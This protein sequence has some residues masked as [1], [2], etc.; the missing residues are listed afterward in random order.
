[1]KVVI[2]GGQIHELN[3]LKKSIQK[4]AMI[5]ANSINV[6][7]SA[8]D[9][10]DI[11][12]FIR[13]KKADCYILELDRSKSR[14]ELA[15][16]IRNSD[17]L[18]S[19]IL[20]TDNSEILQ[21]AF[22]YKIAVLDYIVKNEHISNNVINSLKIAYKRYRQIGK[23]PY[24][25]Y[26]QIEVGEYVKNIPFNEI[27][28]FESLPNSHKIILQAENSRFEFY[29]TLKKV[30]FN[31]DSRFY[32]CHKSYIVNMNQIDEIDKSNHKIKMKNGEYCYASYRLLKSLIYNMKLTRL[33]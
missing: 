25:P 21:L 3:Q 2:Y 28:F 4:Y 14:F 8:T 33:V 12:K 7:L 27:F 11:L 17:P 19:I 22:T 18:A 1:M 9:V 24:I 13:Y 5:E 15:T 16:E 29:G 31:L 10:K 6:I 32:R 23:E 30:S 20:I 26:F